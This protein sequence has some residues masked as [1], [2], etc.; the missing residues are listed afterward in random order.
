MLL[1]ESVRMFERESETFI[2][3]FSSQKEIPVTNG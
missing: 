1:P 3:N 2:R